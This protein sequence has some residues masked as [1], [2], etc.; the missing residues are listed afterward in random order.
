MKK[1]YKILTIAFFACLLFPRAKA[2]REFPKLSETEERILYTSRPALQEISASHEA[3]R[4]AKESREL[5]EKS[6]L[7]KQAI[8][9]FGKSEYSQI[10]TQ[11]V[12]ST[13]NVF[14][15]R[16]L[17]SGSVS[18]IVGRCMELSFNLIFYCSTIRCFAELGHCFG[19]LASITE[20][21]GDLKDAVKLQ[22]QSIFWFRMAVMEN[23]NYCRE[24][25]NGVES[26]KEMLSNKHF[27]DSK[28]MCCCCLL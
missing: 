25:E 1:F 26:L 21:A 6:E 8:Y 18:D 27:N 10:L 3:Y 17:F 19:K 22:K 20:K 2:M 16:P 11:Y 4:K 24:L 5:K 9:G 7:F 12:N 15:C 23:S 28:Y 13:I 14:C